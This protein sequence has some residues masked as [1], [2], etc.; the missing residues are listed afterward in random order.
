MLRRAA[1]AAIAVVALLVVTGGIGADPGGA[2]VPRCPHRPGCVIALDAYQWEVPPYS[3][4][5]D[6]EITWKSDVDVT[7]HFATRDG[8]AIAGR[9]YLPVKDGLVVIPAG[10]TVGHGEVRLVP[11]APPQ[12]DLAFTVTIYDASSGV[13][14]RAEAV[15]TIKAGLPPQ[16]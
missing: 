6:V 12:Q 3:I 16:Q 8:S 4:T 10:A 9:D 1:A 2:A 7:V 11:Q 5:F 13:I 15:L 14:T